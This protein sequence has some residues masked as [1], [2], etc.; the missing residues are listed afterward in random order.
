MSLTSIFSTPS[1]HPHTFFFSLLKSDKPPSSKLG[2]SCNLGGFGCMRGSTWVFP[3]MKQRIVSL[4]QVWNVVALIL[5]SK[6]PSRGRTKLDNGT[7]EASMSHQVRSKH[8]MMGTAEFH[9]PANGRSVLSSL[10]N[11]AEGQVVA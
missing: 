10:P 7:E 5:H 3:S 9:A 6:P 2:T 1:Y 8:I 11:P 4:L